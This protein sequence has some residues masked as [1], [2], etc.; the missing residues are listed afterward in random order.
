MKKH[1]YWIG[2]LTIIGVSLVLFWRTPT[3]AESISPKESMITDQGS[4]KL[5]RI[6]F[7]NSYH[8]GYPWSDGIQRALTDA[9]GLQPGK[10]PETWQ[11]NRFV[12]RVL[13]LNSKRNPTE[14]AIRQAAEV[15]MAMIRDWQ[16]DIVATSD[17]NAVKYVVRPALEE[18]P[19]LPFVF[20]GVNWGTDE[21]DLPPNR[22]AGMIEV[23]LVDQIV[24]HLHPFARGD[25]VAFLK[26]YD[27]SAVKEA[28]SFE[29]FLGIPITR[30]LVKDFSEWQAAY[31]QLQQESDILLLG[32]F[33]SVADWD[34]KKARQLINEETRIPTGAWDAWI[35]EYVLLTFSTVPK[36]QGDW[37]AGTIRGILSGQSP[38]DFGTVRNHKATLYRNMALAK[39][40]KIIFPMEL[41]RRS[42]AVDQALGNDE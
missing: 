8:P 25:R 35:R 12:L 4:N 15:V 2:V 36:E 5:Q 32:N 27:L 16:P 13:Y 40:L 23:Q 30:R 22:V 11:G 7:V 19:S 29:T 24:Q 6:L 34:D 21:Y 18:F 9:L 31:R 28:D 39:Q 38:A 33:T 41:I 10:E 3:W 42:W 17:D 26:G 37:V 14:Q 20:S 1:S